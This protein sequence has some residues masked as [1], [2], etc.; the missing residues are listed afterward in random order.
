MHSQVLQKHPNPN[1]NLGLKT[2]IEQIRKA[3][4]N[5]NS[6]RTKEDERT[7]KTIRIVRRVVVEVEVETKAGIINIQN[8]N[9]MRRKRVILLM[10]V[11]RPLLRDTIINV[12]VDS[13]EDEVVEVAVATMD[14]IAMAAKIPTSLQTLIW[15]VMGNRASVLITIIEVAET[16]RGNIETS[17]RIMMTR[18]IRRTIPNKNRD[19][20]VVVDEVVDVD[21]VPEEATMV[22]MVANSTN[23]KMMARVEAE[24][25][26]EAVVDMEMKD[27]IINRTAFAIVVAKR[28]SRSR[29]PVELRSIRRS[30]KKTPTWAAKA[31]LVLTGSASRHQ[32]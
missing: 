13:D 7:I 8:L 5:S 25:E 26:E 20:A 32:T 22:E 24:V 17:K 28:H 16:T 11:V 12:E 23:R 27:V 10:K 14:R 4:V 31:T 3:K 30:R 18:T 1:N 6:I 29:L 2:L 9:D 15:S 19:V 21:I